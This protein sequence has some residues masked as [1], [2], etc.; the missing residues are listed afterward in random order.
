MTELAEIFVNIFML[1]DYRVHFTLKC[2]ILL[3]K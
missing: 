2:P 1:L 3:A